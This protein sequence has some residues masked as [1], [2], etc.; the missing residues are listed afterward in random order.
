VRRT[1]LGTPVAPAGSRWLFPG[2]PSALVGDGQAMH[3]L[4]GQGGARSLPLGDLRAPVA[5]DTSLVGRCLV[6]HASGYVTAWARAA[7]GAWSALAPP[8]RGLRRGEQGDAILWQPDLGA[9]LWTDRG[10]ARLDLVRGERDDEG[11]HTPPQRVRHVSSDGV[12]FVALLADGGIA[13]CPGQRPTPWLVDDDAPADAVAMAVPVRQPDD[14]VL[15]A[16]RTGAV[17]RG[18]RAA[19]A[20]RGFDWSELVAGVGAVPTTLSCAALA[21]GCA[22]ATADG[23]VRVTGWRHMSP[24]VLPDAQ[25]RAVDRLAGPFP[26]RDGGPRRTRV[27]CADGRLVVV[28]H[29]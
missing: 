3:W 9:L 2:A 23:T 5:A 18:V 1:L 13:H 25:G 14:G 15:V 16:T 12:G 11:W 10:A 28:E 20:E 19:A 8:R 26:A 21:D 4:D 6:L 29:P 17:W 7:D 22:L 27:G 24:L